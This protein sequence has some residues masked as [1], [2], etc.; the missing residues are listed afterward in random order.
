VL[1]L[2]QAQRQSRWILR[3][4]RHFG[5]VALLHRL[6]SNSGSSREWRYKSAQRRGL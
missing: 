1:I 6:I 5:R 3:P 2:G 4:C